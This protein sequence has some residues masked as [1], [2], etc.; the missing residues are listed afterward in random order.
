[1]YSYCAGIYT[2]ICGTFFYLCLCLDAHKAVRALRSVV[3]M[4][5]LP[6]DYIITPTEAAENLG[7]PK[8]TKAARRKNNPDAYDKNRRM[9]EEEKEI[10]RL[11][12]ELRAT[13]D[14]LEIL[15]KAIS[16]LGE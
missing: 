7:I 10:N 12:R 11:K 14:A 5:K 9:S 4:S 1:M 3:C 8:D 15:K 2:G 16:I 6:S 13:K